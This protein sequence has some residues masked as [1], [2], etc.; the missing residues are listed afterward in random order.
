M[1]NTNQKKLNSLM[2]KFLTYFLNLKKDS[3]I[4][5]LNIITSLKII[6]KTV[7]ENR[8]DRLGIQDSDTY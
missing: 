2:F 1:A 7:A 8:N 3:Q 5:S 4:S 6:T